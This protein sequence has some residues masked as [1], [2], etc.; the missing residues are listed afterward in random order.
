M[1]KR[2]SAGTQ[3]AI[4]ISTE[5]DWGKYQADL[6]EK[7]AHDQYCGRSNEEM[8]AYIGNSPIEAASD[9]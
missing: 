6:D 9:L 7:W 4:S 2:K 1:R 8:Q 5:S 3:G